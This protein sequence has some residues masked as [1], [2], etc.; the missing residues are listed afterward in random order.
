MPEL[1]EVETVR[2]GLNQTTLDRTIINGEV[3]LERTVAYPNPEMF[4]AGLKGTKFLNWHRRGKYLLGELNNQGWLG[5][6]LRM[7]GSLLW[8]NQDQ[9]V[10]KHTRVRI[11]LSDRAELRFNDQ[12]TFGQMWLV[13]PGTAPQEIITTLQKLGKEP[14]DPEFSADYLKQKLNKSDRPIKNS[15]LDQAIVAG[16]GNIYADESLFLSR[17]HPQAPSN[18]LTDNQVQQLCEAIIQ[19]LTDGIANGGTTFSD[20]QDVAG[21][22]G[23]YITAAWVFRRTGQPCK[24]CSTMI[25][26]IKLAG[27]STHFCPTCQIASD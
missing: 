18:Q 3:L 19:V 12:R 26:R 13:P 7:T 22:K 11:L 6:H 16:I 20:F 25:E 8:C 2:L 23:N 27:R 9:P 17:I 4:I 15:L 24:I 21:E 1:P 10:H 5:V 14:F